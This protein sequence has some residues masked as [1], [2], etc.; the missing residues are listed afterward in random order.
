MERTQTFVIGRA[1]TAFV[2][3]QIFTCSDPTDFT[4]RVV[5]LPTLDGGVMADLEH[6][7]APSLY[8][9][10]DAAMNSVRGTIAFLTDLDDPDTTWS[11]VDLTQME[12]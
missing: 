6:V 1:G 2:V 12:G 4:S 9:T 7:F 3:W 5:T 8:W 11:L 10:W